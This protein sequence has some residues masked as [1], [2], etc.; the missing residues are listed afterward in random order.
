MGSSGLQRQVTLTK[1]ADPKKHPP[2]KPSLALIS[3]PFTTMSFLCSNMLL[4]KLD[5]P[6]VEGQPLPGE[7]KKQKREHMLE[8]E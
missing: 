7:F 3:Q 1:V 8:R 6:F 5:L 4:K 2:R